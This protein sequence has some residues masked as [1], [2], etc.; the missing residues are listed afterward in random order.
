MQPG[1]VNVMFVD[2]FVE[3][4]FVDFGF[5][6]HDETASDARGGGMGSDTCGIRIRTYLKYS[7]VANRS[8]S[9]PNAEKRMPFGWVL[10]IWSYLQSM[11]L[12]GMVNTSVLEK[13]EGLTYPYPN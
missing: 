10:R 8:P 7:L 5:F 12:R 11:S 1:S 6:V 9:A 3:Q 13:R 2:A 4:V